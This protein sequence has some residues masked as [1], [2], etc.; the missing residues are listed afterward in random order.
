MEF[1]ESE[2]ALGFEEISHQEIGAFFL[3]YW[4]LPE[5]FVETAL[6]HHNPGDA[7]D[8]NRDIVR[9]INLIDRLIDYILAFKNTD[10]IDLSLFEND[11]ISDKTLKEV[12][13]TIKKKLS[14]HVSIIVHD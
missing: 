7:S 3:D 12:I 8:Q 10:T 2:L 6:F 11:L 5:I 1:Y 13:P 9:L 4:N 14:E